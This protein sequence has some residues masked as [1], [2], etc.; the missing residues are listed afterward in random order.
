MVPSATNLLHAGQARLLDQLDAHDRV[1]VEVAAGIGHVGADA[2]DHRGEVYHHVGTGVREHA[3]DVLAFGEVVL[4]APR[5][6]DVLGSASLKLL[7]DEPAQES[8]PAR[9]AHPLVSPVRHRCAPRSFPD[10]GHRL[11]AVP[12]PVVLEPDDVILAKVLAHLHLDELKRHLAD[13]LEPVHAA[14]A[15]GRCPRWRGPRCAR[16]RGSPSPSR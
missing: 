8:G 12:G 7:D 11:L 9:H 10:A 1:L 2:A 14:D 15:A 4:G 6:E 16:H 5:H 13:V 3:N